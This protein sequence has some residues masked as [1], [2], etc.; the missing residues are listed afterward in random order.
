[1]PEGDFVQW[2]RLLK[3]TFHSKRLPQRPGRRFAMTDKMMGDTLKTFML[4]NNA[5]GDRHCEARSSLLFKE[6]VTENLRSIV[7]DCHS[8]QGG[9][10]Q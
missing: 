1:L 3:F 2:I 9:A 5:E 8:A 7:K 6:S 10:S 4:E